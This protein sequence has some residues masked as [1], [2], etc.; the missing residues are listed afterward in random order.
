MT[1]F[2][3]LSQVANLFSCSRS[4]P[5]LIQFVITL[6]DMLLLIQSSLA[7]KSHR[8]PCSSTVS[9]AKCTSLPINKMFL[10][11]LVFQA[12][13]TNAFAAVQIFAELD[14]CENKHW[15]Y[16]IFASFTTERWKDRRNFFRPLIRSLIPISY[17]IGGFSDLL[18]DVWHHFYGLSRL[19]SLKYQCFATVNETRREE[20]TFINC[21]IS[22][23]CCKFLSFFN[24]DESIGMLVVLSLLCA[25]ALLHLCFVNNCRDPGWMSSLCIFVHMMSK[26]HGH[27]WT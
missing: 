21:L 27:V 25:D 7:L 18:C 13:E 6:S 5:T 12:A 2:I 9:T 26:L 8:W 3:F 22:L 23:R 24:V 20:N 4:E 11:C 16:W 15:N 1:W 14:W 10:H 19:L 17:M